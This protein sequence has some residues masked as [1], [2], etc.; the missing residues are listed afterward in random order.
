[1]QALNKGNE[2]TG[3][4]DLTDAPVIHLVANHTRTLAKQED[5]L[6]AALRDAPHTYLLMFYSVISNDLMIDHI[7][8]LKRVLEPVGTHSIS[9]RDRP[10]QSDQG[11]GSIKRPIM[12]RLCQVRPTCSGYF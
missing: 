9:G 4:W 1:M 2:R 11:I 3:E 5:T 6:D 10:V 7:S 8:V 12:T